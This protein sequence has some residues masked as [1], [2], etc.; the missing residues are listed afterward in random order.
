M[1]HTLKEAQKHKKIF[2]T[3]TKSNLYRNGNK[4]TNNFF[5]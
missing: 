2:E 5:F 4:E 3:K 1:K